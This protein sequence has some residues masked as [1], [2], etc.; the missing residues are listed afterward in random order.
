M[1]KHYGEK[2]VEAMKTKPPRMNCRQTLLIVLAL[3]F[4]FGASL[5]PSLK[6]MAAGDEGRG[7]QLQGDQAQGDQL[8]GDQL[9][10]D[11]AQGDQLEGDQLQGDQTQGD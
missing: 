5:V 1:T 4:V 7:N 11:Q 9:Q 8:Q 3:I 10:G 6:T 2:G